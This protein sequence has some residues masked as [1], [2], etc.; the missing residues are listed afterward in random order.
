VIYTI[1]GE[2]WLITKDMKGVLV[3][4]VLFMGIQAYAIVPDTTVTSFEIHFKRKSSDEALA[5]NTTLIDRQ[6]LYTR[7][8]RLLKNKLSAGQFKSLHDP[9]VLLKFDEYTTEHRSC[10]PDEIT[11]GEER[12]LKQHQYNYFVKIYGQLSM[13]TPFDPFHKEVFTLRVCVFDAQGKLVAK[14]KSR[15]TVRD[16]RPFPNAETREAQAVSITE[17]DFVDLVTDALT[18]LHLQI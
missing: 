12:S 13:S 7:V 11:F 5:F 8:I 9:Q 4:I 2:R 18:N 3:G 10:H 17:K 16:I 6:V 14:G 1:Q 15:S